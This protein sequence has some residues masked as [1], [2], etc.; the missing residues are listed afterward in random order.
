MPKTLR[1]TLELPCEGAQPADLDALVSL[2]LTH[3]LTDPVASVQ[4]SLSRHPFAP[5]GHLIEART[6]ERQPHT[7]ASWAVVNL[8]GD[9]LR[10]DL[11][12]L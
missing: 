12:V 4:R 2:V 3:G 8:R 11:L 1:L 10:D 9:D 7:A 6:F 5:F